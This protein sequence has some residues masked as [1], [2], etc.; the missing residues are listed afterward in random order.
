MRR[1][2]SIFCALA[3]PF[4][5]GVVSAHA[6][7][8]VPAVKPAPDP[9]RGR[10]KGLQPRALPAPAA[11]LR[12]QLSAANERPRT[13]RHAS[14]V[15]GEEVAAMQATAW[16]TA[17]WTGA[18]V[19]V[20]VIDEFDMTLWAT[21]QGNGELP[22]PAATFCIDIGVSCTLGQPPGTHGNAI[23]EIVTET[24]PG[25]QLYLASG[26]STSDMQ[27]VVNWLQ[28]MG[29]T[30]VVAAWAW[31]YDGPGDGTGP[32]D[33]VADSAVAKGM[34][35]VKAAGN[36]ADGGYWRGTVANNLIA[37]VDKT[38]PIASWAN[39]G[40]KNTYY[41]F[42]RDAQ[43][44]ALTL[45]AVAACSWIQG[46]RWSD[47]GA[48][49]TD[50][51][52]E[53]WDDGL[54]GN[55]YLLGT[56][57]ADQLAG[58][59]PLEADGDATGNWQGNSCS[60]LNSDGITWMAIRYKYPP[61][62]STVQ[63]NVVNDRLEISVADGIAGS[64]AAYSAA[65]PITD[66]RNPGVLAVGAQ[67][68]PSTNTVAD[69]SSRGPTNDGRIKPDIVAPAGVTVT[70]FGTPFQGTSA[71]TAAAAGLAALVQEG[72]GAR[73]GALGRYLQDNAQDI[74]VVGR[75]NDSG[76]G[77]ARVL[78]P[79][80]H[81]FDQSRF[82]ALAEPLRVLETRNGPPIAPDRIVD[83][84]L[85]KAPSPVPA[86][87]TAVVLN[88][89]ATNTFPGWVQ[90]FPTAWSWVGASSNLN[91]EFAGR[92]TP[93]LVVVPI[94]ADRKVSL[95]STGGGHL[96]A[97]LFG[98]FVPATSASSGRFVSL[99]PFR[100]IDSRYC[101]GIEGVPCTGSR[102]LGSNEYYTFRITDRT[103]PGNAANKIPASGV[104]AVVLNV[105]ATDALSVGWMQVAPGNTTPNGGAFSN[106]NYV[107][108]QTVP[109]L[110]VVPVG[111]DGNIRFYASG[112]THFIADVAGYFTDATAADSA[113][114]LFT[115]VQ[116][117]RPYDSRVGPPLAGGTGVDV[118]LPGKA[119]IPATGASSIL[120][121]LTATV[122]A[123]W[124]WIQAYPTGQAAIG[125]S[126]NVNVE[127]PNQTI[128]NAAITR[129]G[130]NDNISLYTS[131]GTHLIVDTAGWFAT[132]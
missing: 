119:G 17:S 54:D 28:S 1:L 14:A 63:T 61:G 99:S 26:T 40:A 77:K 46:F 90:V 106:L 82:V 49:K 16:Q 91:P 44:N 19:K 71:S 29:V 72:T 110:V 30:I 23:S 27:A 117:G 116:P 55:T 57:D 108:G 87:A 60:D 24:A 9:S 68:G 92:A 50:Y 47:W 76:A 34:L 33:T 81:A 65:S 114:G 86:E 102:R 69:Y 83:L 31:S 121:N 78:A 104:S 13:Q 67:S 120:F 10:A 38:A 20:G 43:G 132:G 48:G 37:N 105:T 32:M 39:Y 111:A 129:L 64:Q 124:G 8:S 41:S 126:S 88:V 79:P 18:G 58:A 84:D 103:D 74:S 109:N 35:F 25:A 22:A 6:K 113:T 127:R 53:E 59:P 96:F 125:S 5:G 98:W 42:A 7:S 66:S 128:A 95:Y 45:T 15:T 115:P 122:S 70:S 51:I 2:V 56:W 36:S 89:T 107:T 112:A 73:A 101:T 93:N 94:G 123:G 62:K 52:L 131:V 3:L 21:Q 80:P 118:K 97:D 75:D 12:Q 85:A 4:V 130:D 11:P 100:V